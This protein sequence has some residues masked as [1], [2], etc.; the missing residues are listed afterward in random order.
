MKFA[1]RIC[2]ILLGAIF[3]LALAACGEKAESGFTVSLA[4]N[5]EQGDASL[6]APASGETYAA[7]EQVTLTVVAK[8][9]YEVLSVTVDG[10]PVILENGQYSFAVE[11]DTAVTVV[12]QATE[13][14]F[15]VA[16][17]LQTV[18]GKATFD[19][20]YSRTFTD[21][22]Y[23]YSMNAIVSFGDG[24][25]RLYEAN[26]RTQAV[27][28]DYIAVDHNGEL[29][30]I[31]HD[32]NNAIAY[33]DTGSSF[34]DAYNPLAKLTADDLTA[35]GEH[36][37]RVIDAEKAAVV[38][39]AI[40]GTTENVDSVELT[41]RG[42]V[43]AVLTVKSAD[44]LYIQMDE[45]YYDALY[46]YNIVDVGK[47]D[48]PE[49]YDVPYETIPEHAALSAALQATAE[50]GSYVMDCTET[51]VSDSANYK[52]YVTD[53]AIYSDGTM[54]GY[55][56][57]NGAT[58][59]FSYDAA[60]EDIILGSELTTGLGSLMASFSGFSPA[61]FSYE[62]DDVYVFRTDFY[63]AGITSGVAGQ[64]ASALVSG[65][66]PTV[67]YAVDLKISVFDGYIQQIYFT[68]FADGNEGEFTIDL[69]GFGETEQPLDLSSAKT[70][71]EKYVG[72]YAGRDLVD[73]GDGTYEYVDYGLTVT[74][75][76]FRFTIRGEETVAEDLYVTTALGY[77][78]VQFR[79]GGNVYMIYSNEG[80]NGVGLLLVSEDYETQV[81]LMPEG[82]EGQEVPTPYPFI[83]YGTYEYV[84]LSDSDDAYKIVIGEQIV[85]TKNGEETTVTGDIYYTG[86]DGIS[87]VYED[88][89]WFIIA[90]EYGSENTVQQIALMNGDDSVHVYLDRTGE[91]V[92]PEK[93]FV[94]P[95][96]YVGVFT[97]TGTMNGEPWQVSVEFTSEGI[98]VI[99]GGDEAV[100]PEFTFDEKS[101]NFYFTIGNV[102]YVIMDMTD[103][104]DL[105]KPVD[106]LQIEDDDNYRNTAT[107][108]R[109]SE[110]GDSGVTLPQKFLGKFSGT[111]SDGTVYTLLFE[112][113]GVTASKNEEAGVKCAYTKVESGN[114]VYFLWNG[115]E[116]DVYSSDSVIEEMI[117]WKGT[118]NVV[119]L[120]PVKE[121]GG[122]GGG[123]G[124]ETDPDGHPTYDII[125]HSAVGTWVGTSGGKTYTFKITATTFCFIIDGG[126]PFY[127]TDLTNKASGDS[128]DFYFTMDGVQYNFYQMGTRATLMS[129]EIMLSVQFD[130]Q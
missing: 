27:E 118:T 121:G 130:L 125:P 33:W 47:G 60:S 119:T 89:F 104:A 14:G 75:T 127:P 56:L 20:T 94:M 6:T 92:E 7:G 38:A 24:A 88:A 117:L 51:T 11:H 83:F 123:G 49:G 97:G 81:L 21:P 91:G 84:A 93:P 79:M 108:L 106:T 9:G 98:S 36:T 71:F 39:Y 96:R 61:L 85:I 129:F 62:G 86:V 45:V 40:T 65:G 3:A 78:I 2:L 66:D 74:E 5:A 112:A 16:A 41:E 55:M 76:E 90:E 17:A 128:F 57:K 72:V 1:K 30:L 87:I 69:S 126:E 28:Y 105:T 31:Y 113:D 52:I 100:E 46:E 124:G 8:D 63:L 34:E 67:A 35:V 59:V 99:F 68:Y 77:L 48:I 70:L 42:G 54:T 73:K 64:C 32:V 116:Y 22:M 43:F 102:H 4:Y 107:L 109:K 12:F 50:A 26:A 53:D 37:Y 115:E 103:S 122:E 19:G 29:A 80:P 95:E 110:G 25:I 111:A 120:K 13:S 18:S 15:N 82:S 101:R 44:N 10:A 23:D 114:D 58:Y